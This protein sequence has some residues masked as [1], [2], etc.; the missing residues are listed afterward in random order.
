MKGVAGLMVA[1]ECDHHRGLPCVEIVG[2]PDASVREATSRIRPA[3]RNAGFQFPLARLTINLSPAWQHKLGVG[4]D[5]PMAVSVLAAS[6]QLPAGATERCALVGELAL[7]GRVMPVKGVIP[8][9]IAAASAGL[10][11]VVVPAANCR[12]ACL[13]P[14]VTVVPVA[15]LVQAV[16]FLRS[17]Q[18]PRLPEP[19]GPGAG[20]PAPEAS[21][22]PML[23][24][25]HVLGQDAAVRAMEVAIAGGHHV[26][27]VGPP[28]TGKT[29]LASCAADVMPPLSDSEWLATASI[30]SIA[31][32]D[33]ASV[34]SRRRPFRQPNHTT[35]VAGMLGGGV[36]PVPGEVT[37]A[38]TGILFLDELAQFAPAVIRSLAEP[39]EKR[40]VRLM[41]AGSAVSYPADFIMVAC[42]NPCPCG[43]H[44]YRPEECTCSPS[45][46]ASYRRR[47][48]G[49]TADRI[50]IRVEVPR[51]ESARL[52]V[53]SASRTT[54]AVRRRIESARAIQ[55]E[56][57]GREGA[58]NSHVAPGQVRRLL[59]S[60]RHA[61]ALLSSAVD[62]FGMSV[63]AYHSMIKVARTI[64]DLD[65]SSEIREE[66]VLEALGYRATFFGGVER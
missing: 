7:D 47:L 53:V 22:E 11:H 66:H 34:C 58:T 16:R 12:E 60:G 30:R 61:A 21:T 42:A 1:V 48:G 20:D 41:R 14:G 15:D 64:A 32:E 3:L 38:H 29:M 10:S 50:D 44:G 51:R 23:D 39:M 6:G 46:L 19:A 55:A 26:L 59:S 31:G 4:L 57:Y 45:T 9:C 25:A 43:M 33:V 56:R 8:A 52:T 18:M 40:V 63:R 28:G 37:L 24:V 62:R 35:T 49:P 5:L 36:P 2:L 54:E 27:L 17:G 13:V 65:G